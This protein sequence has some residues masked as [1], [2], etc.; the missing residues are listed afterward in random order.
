MCLTELGWVL[1]RH[2]TSSA[3]QWLPSASQAQGPSSALA[4]LASQDQSG[5]QAR[6]PDPPEKPG[7]S[8]GQLPGSFHGQI[9]SRTAAPSPA[10]V[11]PFQ[12]AFLAFRI[13]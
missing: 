2:L 6:L 5:S 4:D 8:Q 9:S 3:Q 12:C 13:L 7:A 1:H 10:E 11:T